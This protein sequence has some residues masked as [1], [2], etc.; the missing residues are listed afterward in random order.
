[1][2]ALQQVAARAGCSPATASRALGLKECVSDTMNRR[3]R[4]AAAE[5]GYRST[6]AVG[7]AGRRPVIGVL[8]PSITNSVISSSLSGIENRM[9]VAT[10]SLV[11]ASLIVAH[12]SPVTSL[13][14]V[15][16]ILS[17]NLHA[18]AEI[19]LRLILSRQCHFHM[20]AH[21]LAEPSFLPLFIDRSQSGAN[22]P[23]A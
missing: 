9:L 6:P 11:A 3:V 23:S 15:V 19:N 7:K 20:S 14:T 21:L 10:A 13:S 22:W 8:I 2:T 16:S 5:L 4:R 17:H 18:M 12:V 1:M